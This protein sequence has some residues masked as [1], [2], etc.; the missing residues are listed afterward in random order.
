MKA[1]S[2]SHT[3]ITVIDFDKF[4]QFYAEHFGCRLVAVGDS[5]PTWIRGF[6]GVEAEQPKCRIGWLRTPGGGMLEIF[7]FT[8]QQPAKEVAWNRVGLT[9]ISIDVKNSCKWHENLKKKGVEIVS[10]VQ[11]SK[12]GHTFFFAKDCDGN[13][14]EL[15]DLKYRYPLLRYLGWLGG[16]IFRRGMYRKHYGEVT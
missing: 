8:P 16:W 1:R 4:V 6:F 15:I 13:L 2:F 7:E 12:H 14:I 9:H 3:G 5:E 11:E 10:E